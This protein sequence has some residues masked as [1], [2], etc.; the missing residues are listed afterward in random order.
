MKINAKLVADHLE[1]V[2][3]GKRVKEAVLGPNFT[4]Q[5]VDEQDEIMLKATLKDVKFPG[6]I[7]VESVADLAKLIA[8]FGAEVD[9]E[10]KDKKLILGGGT[11]TVWYQLYD[12]EKIGTTLS[13]FKDADAAITKDIVASVEPDET[14]LAD[15]T[16][17]QKRISPDLV[18]FL[19]KGKKLIANLI[20]T[21]G[22]RAEV[23][24]GAADIGKKKFGAL[25]VSAQAVVDVLSGVKPGED[26]QLT[27]SVGKSLKVE[28]RTYTYL[29]SARVE[30]A[31]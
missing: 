21:D 10:V 26:D 7:G 4:A 24:V 23:I 15:F 11:V 9:A 29:V 28:F 25:K 17:Y 18:E 30:A 6:K 5:V 2:A 8:S 22:H 14:F 13:S 12:V 19:V 16:K 3:M 31:D 27:I 1:M 20:S